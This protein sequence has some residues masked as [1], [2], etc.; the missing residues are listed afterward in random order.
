MNNISFFNVFVLQT[1]VMLHIDVSD[2]S[3]LIISQ[4][5]IG[6][7]IKVINLFWFSIWQ[8]I[9]VSHSHKNV[10]LL[11]TNAQL[12][13]YKQKTLSMSKLKLL[14]CFM[15]FFLLC[16]KDCWRWRWW[17]LWNCNH[18]EHEEIPGGLLYFFATLQVVCCTS[19][20]HFYDTLLSTNV[21]EKNCCIW[22]SVG[23]G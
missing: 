22:N 16:V 15:I 19:L 8:F 6:S 1:F 11:T 21:F 10:Q 2:M 18:T 13:V 4:N 9:V 17:S 20:P 14:I 23:W 5:K 3:D 7:T 12:Q